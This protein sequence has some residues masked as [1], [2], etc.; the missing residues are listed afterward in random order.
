[1][2]AMCGTTGPELIEVLKDLQV[3]DKLERCSPCDKNEV[4]PEFE[5]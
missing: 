3:Q 1:M 4:F 5:N 2:R